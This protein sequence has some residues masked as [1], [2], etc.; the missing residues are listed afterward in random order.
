MA[1]VLFTLIGASSPGTQPLNVSILSSVCNRAGHETSLFDTTFM[2]LGF[3]L[4]TEVSQR[5]TV[6]EKIDYTKLNL[7][8]ED[9]DAKKL[10]LKNWMS[11][12]LM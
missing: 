6:F 1:N 2:D 3:D 11:L 7:V 9:V 12:S 5:D 8:R 4:D 10:F